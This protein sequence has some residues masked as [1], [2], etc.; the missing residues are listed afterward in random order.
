MAADETVGKDEAEGKDETTSKDDTVVKPEIPFEIRDLYAYCKLEHDEMDQEEMFEYMF[1]AVA[2]LQTA[3]IH[4]P[5]KYLES[6][7]HTYRRRVQ[8]RSLVRALVLDAIDHPGAQIGANLQEN[9]A[10]RRTLNQMKL[11]E[12][13]P[14]PDPIWG[15]NPWDSQG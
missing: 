15:S 13:E 5:S 14:D 12:P 7:G 1:Q 10:F 11:S 6:S 8:Y 9:R 4:N 2:Y 3:G